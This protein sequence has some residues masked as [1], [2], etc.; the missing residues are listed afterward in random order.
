MVLYEESFHK[1]KNEIFERND[2]ELRYRQSLTVVES[3][4]D[5]IKNLTIKIS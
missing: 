3:E 1:L 5:H 2:L 4:T